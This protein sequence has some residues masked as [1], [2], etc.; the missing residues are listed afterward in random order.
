MVY[1]QV[2]IE[3][4]PEEKEVHVVVIVSKHQAH[5]CFPMFDTFQMQQEE[6]TTALARHVQLLQWA[7]SL[8]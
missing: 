6:N 3:P 1:S 8:N 7:K 2:V 4:K 5:N